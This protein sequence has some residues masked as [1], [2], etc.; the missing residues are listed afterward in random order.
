M[1]ARRG[2]HLLVPF[3]CDQCVIRGLR[4]VSPGTIGGHHH[5]KEPDL[6]MAVQRV[7]LDS[8][9]SRESSVVRS[10]EAV[11][12]RAIN[13]S[14]S[15]KF[16]PLFPPRSPLPEDVDDIAIAILSVQASLRPGRYKDYSQYD[17][18]CGIRSAYRNLA[19]SS[20][21]AVTKNWTLAGDNRRATRLS[22]LATD[23]L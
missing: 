4:R 15:L 17:T 7:I 10:K 8:F 19:R 21:G 16:R 11:V 3:R 23:S 12:R 18:I 9:R 13:D 14:L 1:T 22:K 5:L 6:K 20:A 2:D